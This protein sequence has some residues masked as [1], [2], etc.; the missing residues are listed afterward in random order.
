MPTRFYPALLVTEPGK[1]GVGVVFPDLPG[2]VSAGAS[3]Q[4]AATQA[5]E[6]LALHVEGTLADGDELPAPGAV[7]APLPDWLDGTAGEVA[8]RV[9]VPVEVPAKPNRTLR[10]NVMLPED[11]LQAIDRVSGNRSRF[12]TEAAR[13]KLREVA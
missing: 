7:D 9:L 2:C 5:V 13:A 11:V 8:A 6:A 10:V 12:L 4:D 1:P 3:V